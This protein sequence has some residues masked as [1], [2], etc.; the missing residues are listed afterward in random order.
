[1]PAAVID[2]ADQARHTEFGD[3]FARDVGRLLN[4]AHRAHGVVADYYFFCGSAAHQARQLARKLAHGIEV[5]V[6]FGTVHRKAARIAARYDSDF[7]NG[8]AA[9]CLARYDSVPRLVISGD[10]LIERRNVPRF[11]GRT[12][13]HF[14]DSLE[15]IVH[16]NARAVIA[17]GEYCRFVKHV[18]EIRARKPD[19]YLRYA[20]KIDVRRERFVAR[21]N[22]E[23]RLSAANVGKIDVYL[24]VE[25]AR[26]HERGIEN[27]GTVGSRH[28]D[29][30]FVGL[31]T[32]HSDEQLV[33]RLLAL[34]VAAAHAR[35]AL[36]ADR[37]DLVYK[38]YARRVL[39]CLF[40]QIAHARRA[41]A[42]EHFHKVRAGL[43]EKRHVRLARNGFCKQCFT[44]SGRTYQQHAVRHARAHSSEFLRI[45]EK[46][47]NLFEFLFFF[48]RAR[49]VR[50]AYLQLILLLR[51]GPA[52]IH[53]LLVRIVHR[54]E[55]EYH[56]HHEQDQ[57]ERGNDVVRYIYGI[58][59]VQYEYYLVFGGF[60][61]IERVDNV[62]KSRVAN[63]NDVLDLFFTFINNTCRV[64]GKMYL[65][66]RTIA[67]Y[68][69]V[70]ILG[71]LLYFLN[72]IRI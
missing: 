51:F 18:F 14:V 41:H 43:A 52:E 32:V 15:Y 57:P 17:R 49:N 42:D 28:Y 9:L 20:L 13:F 69:S 7:L 4:I 22:F 44:R 26:T 54:S 64:V 40:K 39:F 3:H 37:V 48:F 50:K 30:M 72:Q 25:S 1:M 16:G 47:D 38:H 46:F 59:I 29:D 66:D 63:V 68:I 65:A 45:F 36:T 10:T 35:A 2:R 62:E 34:V 61:L 31:E 56:E 11:F 58:A 24:S 23:Y 8:I 21:V 6:V 19:R 71:R 12:H 55:H 5:A 67:Y 53:R 27:V 60:A 33:E 70:L